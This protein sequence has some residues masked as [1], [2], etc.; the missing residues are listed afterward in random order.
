MDAGGTLGTIEELPHDG[1]DDDTFA[2]QVNLVRCNVHDL[3]KVA[4]QLINKR[5]V[6]ILNR[7]NL[8]VKTLTRPRL[9]IENQTK[10]EPE[11]RDCI[12]G[13]RDL[14]DESVDV[15]VTSPPYNL[16]IKWN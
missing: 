9:C 4:Q 6:S 7:G 15:V 2:F 3:R 12:Q 8:I 14:P 1:M 13:M 5:T 11:V 16:G 10:F